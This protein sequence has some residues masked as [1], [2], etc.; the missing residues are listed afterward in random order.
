[1]ERQDREDL[2]REATGLVERVEL[3]VDGWNDP[4][5]V[6]FR[7]NGAITFFFGFDTVDQFNAERQWRRGFDHGLLLKADGG[8]IAQMR[9]EPTEAASYLVRRDYSLAE[10]EQYLDRARNRL[11]RLQSELRLGN[12]QIIG[13]VPPDADIIG[14][15]QEWLERL[16]NPLVIAK[17]PRV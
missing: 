2:L 10:C 15:I 17:S 7:R 4:I 3:K 11:L 14:R 1:M 13:Q 5:V 6:G 16:P 8:K 12:Y 9:R